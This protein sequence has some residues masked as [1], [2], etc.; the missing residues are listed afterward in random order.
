MPRTAPNLETETDGSIVVEGTTWT[1]DFQQIAGNAVEIDAEHTL[2]K[3]ADG[4]GVDTRYDALAWAYAWIGCN[5]EATRG[6]IE[7]APPEYAK[8]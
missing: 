4:L 7:A 5:H 8:P 6:E 1:V 2:I 3:M